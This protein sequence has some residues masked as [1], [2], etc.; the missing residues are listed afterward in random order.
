L[1]A[2]IYKPDKFTKQD[3]KE[4]S[5][6][7]STFLVISADGKITLNKFPK[8]TFGNWDK[9]EIDVINGSGTWRASS[10]SGTTYIIQ[11]LFLIKKG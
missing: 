2:G 10:E 5:H 3:F 11:I 6:L 7:D 8:S 1:I 9:S 4:Y